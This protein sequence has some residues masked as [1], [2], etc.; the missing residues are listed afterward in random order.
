MRAEKCVLPTALFSSV[1]LLL[2]FPRFGQASELF[3]PS[4]IRGK[5]ISVTSPLFPCPF[6][7]LVLSPLGLDL[8]GSLKTMRRFSFSPFPLILWLG[9]QYPLYGCSLWPSLPPPS[10][11][12]ARPTA[13]RHGH[14][15]TAA[16]GGE[17]GGA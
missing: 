6:F 16:D 14:S 4:P 7:L 9:C 5:K 1:F 3:P 2:L 15:H 8:R 17:E 11:Y 12:H 10:W 13:N